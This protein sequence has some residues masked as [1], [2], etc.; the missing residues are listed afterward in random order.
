[1]GLYK[2]GAFIYRMLPERPRLMVKLRG[3]NSIGQRQASLAGATRHCK[4]CLLAVLQMVQGTLPALGPE[5][6]L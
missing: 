3:H 1:M 4:L 5:C 2:G 6:P